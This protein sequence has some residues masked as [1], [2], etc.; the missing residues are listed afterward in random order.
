[1]KGVIKYL[2]KIITNIVN[3]DI[4]DLDYRTDSLKMLFF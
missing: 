1:M 3:K 2:I 4:E